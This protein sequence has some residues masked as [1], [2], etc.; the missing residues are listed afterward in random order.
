MPTIPK[1]LLVDH[2]ARFVPVARTAAATRVGNGAA[3]LCN[4]VT[5][6][7]FRFGAMITVSRCRT[8]AVKSL[9]CD[10]GTDHS[11]EAW[12]DSFSDAVRQYC[13]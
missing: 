2:M 7:M 3:P 5:E 12:N 1:A 4:T 8:V 6:H 9:H 13:R 11:A 10:G